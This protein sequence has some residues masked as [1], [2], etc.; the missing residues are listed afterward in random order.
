VI[1]QS[2]K[3]PDPKNCIIFLHATTR[4]SLPCWI[5]KKSIRATSPTMIQHEVMERGPSRPHRFHPGASLPT[6]QF[7][8][9]TP[10]ATCSAEH[11]HT[12][13]RP[14]PTCDKNLAR[15][16]PQQQD[17][18]NNDYFEI[19][20]KLTRGATLRKEH[21]QAFQKPPPT[22]DR[23]QDWIMNRHLCLFSKVLSGKRVPP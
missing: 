9:L 16:V 17:M 11:Y 13:R 3:F 4:E 15:R 6:M 8:A 10:G 21:Y 14:P 20:F 5:H 19:Y 7:F 23:K 18:H 1:V 12:F 2:Y 22:R